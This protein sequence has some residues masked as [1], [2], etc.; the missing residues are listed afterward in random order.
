MPSF[1]VAQ[2]GG[3]SNPSL[4]I[5]ALNPTDGPYYLFNA[6]SPA[7]PQASVVIERGR[8]DRNDA[9]ITFLIEFA[10]APTD[11]VEIL[12]TNDP[13]ALLLFNLNQWQVLYTSNNNIVDAYTD[14]GR[15]R[16]YCA[17]VASEGAGYPITVIAQR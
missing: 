14:T 5:T 16:Y 3:N 15:Y 7:A 9:G 17:Y 10:S 8:N 6:E 12:G 13:S 2:S 1:G 11:S 4:N